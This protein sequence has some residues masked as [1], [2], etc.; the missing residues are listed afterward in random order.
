LKVMTR[1]SQRQWRSTSM[2][3][4]ATFCLLAVQTLLAADASSLLSKGPY[5]QAP[6][7]DTM[8]ILWESMTNCPATVRFGLPNRRNKEFGP[9]S[10]RTMVGLTPCKYTNVVTLITNGLS[11]TKTNVKRGHLTNLFYL[12][13]A[14]LTG[15][16]PGATYSYSVQVGGAATATHQFKTFSA[17]ADTV[18]FIA[19]GDSRSHPK[20]HR[21][22]A[23]RFLGASPDFVLHTG[24]LVM[25]GRDYGLWSKQFFDPVADVITRVPVLPVP[26]NHEEDLKNYLA[27]F[28]TP[29]TKR[30][31]SFDAGL[32][33]VLAL[34]YHFQKASDEQFKFAREDLLNS[35]AKWKVVLLHYPMFNYGHHNEAWGHKAY[36]P[37]FQEAKVDL[38]LAGHSHLYERFRPIAPTDKRD[39]WAITFVTTGGGGAELGN[40]YEHP[41]HAKCISTNH[42]VAFEATEK[43]LRGRAVRADGTV[44]DSFEIKKT[45]G[46]QS[47]SYLAQV[48]PQEWLAT[49]IELG[50]SLLGKLAAVPTNRVATP[51]MFSLAPIK[52]SERPLDLEISLAPDSAPFYELEEGPLRV[53]TPDLCE[54]NQV[55]WARVRATGK[56]KIKGPEL[57]PPLVFQARIQGGAG[58]TL[59]YGPLSRISQ[60]AAREAKKRHGTQPAA[61]EQTG[62]GLDPAQL[63]AS[64]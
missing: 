48:Y 17:K 4:A 10:P 61:S 63:N 36:L 25:D 47:K 15:L 42:F 27:Y 14:R 38:V 24:D 37:L 18:R 21:S 6:G 54:S 55:I 13:E 64:K 30:W 12:Y 16:K 8:T 60:T 22:L 57:S 34:D 41:A 5:L 35:R 19:Y 20:T 58:D 40:V 53:S 31:Y 49:S 29:G 1:K 43:M 32:V 52:T 46:V 56:K 9:I 39:A 28:H 2:P 26:G 23:K 51:V 7:S 3:V 33:H 59:A 50:P 11:V 62:S 45:R 44:I